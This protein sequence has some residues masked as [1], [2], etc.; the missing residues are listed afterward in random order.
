MRVR[1]VLRRPLL[2]FAVLLLV[3]SAGFCWL[4]WNSVQTE[5]QF[6]RVE[7]ERGA[8]DAAARRAQEAAD[9]IERLRAREESRHY[10]EYQ[11]AFLPESL[12]S[13]SLAFQN[14][15][16]AGGRDDARVVA[17]FEWELGPRGPY[18]APRL[19]RGDAD[20]V[21][22]RL[23]SVFGPLLTYELSRA[24]ESE[25]LRSGRAIDYPLHVV[26]ANE[27]RGQLLEEIL[28]RGRQQQVDIVQQSNRFNNPDVPGGTPY[29]DA[30]Q[31]RMSED[32]VTV[33]YTRFRYAAAPRG[34]DAAPL[35]AWRLV[36]IP[37][38][39]AA[40]RE[41]R[42][43][44]FLVQGYALDPA[45]TLPTA[46]STQGTVQ[47]GRAL[48]TGTGPE[49]ELASASL[50][51]ALG[52]A[53]ATPEGNAAYLVSDDQ[54][55][56][57]HAAL[58]VVG[59]PDEGALAKRFGEA[60]RR[61]LFLV[62]GLVT[63]VVVGFIVLMRGVRR[64]VALARRKEDFIAA[65]THELKTPLTGI[66]MYADMLKQGWVADSEASQKYATRILDE[67][68][69]LG[70][71][72][73]QVLDLAAL[74]RGVAA[75]SATVGDLGQAVADA[76]E[77]MRPRADEAAVA[78]D[79]ELEADLPHVAFDPKLVRPL[80]LN[81]VDN[82]IKYSERSETKAVRVSVFRDGERVCVR[83]ADEG[84]G[85]PR[86]AR[87]TLF[88]PFQR[89]G[90]ELTRDAPGVGI[91]LALV[92]RYADAHRAR[93]VLESEKGVGT[94]ITVRFPFS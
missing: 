29:L 30:F 11:R 36:W 7:M 92:K 17:R 78:L 14:N 6:R 77:L 8:R 15:A 80:V 71:L 85:I 43:D 37:D 70:H 41:V 81:L 75:Y 5:G 87:K 48:E 90:G 42:R 76:T 55:F 22:R 84:V 63:V 56:V 35:V 93:I 54:P 45:G 86:N 50:A 1:Q 65:I 47:L 38:A 10:Y 24:R 91:G 44:R 62:G 51:A 34:S 67:T 4:G 61:F 57:A 31:R 23:T 53:L 39:H 60:L 3:P 40:R 46:W 28:V 33:R 66:R 49:A 18:P 19:I 68:R 32:R 64:E 2:I 74:E 52:A 16:L 59:R 79:T 9:S 83:V 89:A 27:E 20:T 13:G 58:V 25:A 73:N 82:A 12:T 72:V 69:R 94:T 21:G 88:E 26:A